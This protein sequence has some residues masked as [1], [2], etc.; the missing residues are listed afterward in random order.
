MTSA[1][2]VLERVFSL[3][4]MEVGLVSNQELTWFPSRVSE[5]LNDSSL[6][7]SY[8]ATRPETLLTGELFVRDRAFA[9]R[10]ES[11]IFELPAIIE[12]IIAMTKI[13]IESSISENARL[14]TFFL[15]FKTK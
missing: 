5:G 11:I 9:N 3:F 15:T 12:T 10:A 7:V 14:I 1:D 6:E 8:Q 4:F 2:G 13:E